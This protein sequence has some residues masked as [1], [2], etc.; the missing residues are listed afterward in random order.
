MG[1]AQ[2]ELALRASSPWLILI[3]SID[4]EPKSLSGFNDREMVKATHS[5]RHH[6]KMRSIA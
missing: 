2:T 3:F 4:I 1:L 6:S 5:F